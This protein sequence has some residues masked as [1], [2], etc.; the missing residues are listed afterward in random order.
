GRVGAARVVGEEIDDRMPADLFLAVRADAQVHGQV[1]GLGEELRRLEHAPELALVVRDTARDE[2]LA[3]D[4][5]LERRRLPELERCGRLDVEVAVQKD[6]R[7]A[8]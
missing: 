7:G 1:T 6:G 3:A 8:G 4:G 5:Q 2:P